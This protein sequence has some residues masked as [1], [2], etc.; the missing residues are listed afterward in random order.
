M[1]VVN[2]L[3]SA[4]AQPIAQEAKQRTDLPPLKIVPAASNPAACQHLLAMFVTGHHAGSAG[5]AVRFTGAGYA[6]HHQYVSV[7]L[8]AW[9]PSFKLKRGPVGSRFAVDSGHQLLTCGS[10]D[11]GRYGTENRRRRCPDD[12]GG[13]FGTLMLASCT[14][15]FISLRSA[16]ARRVITPLVSGVVVMIIGLSL[17]Q[18]V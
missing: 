12:D 15:M 13:A 8:P 17:I 16:P 7:S 14:E 18:V 3:E 9:P 1:S 10:A 6:T 5:F 2:T 4:D 11:H